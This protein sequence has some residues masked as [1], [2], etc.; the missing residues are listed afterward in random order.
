MSYENN[1]KFDMTTTAATTRAA[2][3]YVNGAPWRWSRSPQRYQLEEKTAGCPLD[4][5]RKVKPE[6]LMEKPVRSR[7]SGRENFLETLT[8]HLMSDP[9]L[10]VWEEERG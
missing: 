7:R 3:G 1:F 2:G 6:N 8:S 9:T 4:A 10:G 5:E